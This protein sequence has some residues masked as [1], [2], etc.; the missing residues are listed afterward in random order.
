MSSPFSAAHFDDLHE[1]VQLQ[2][3]AGYLPLAAIVDQAVEIF[4]DL[5]IDPASARAAATAV[6][7]R[8]VAAHRGAQ[9]SWPPVTDCDRLDAAF[10]EL[11]GAGVLAR[12]HYRCCATCATQDILEELQQADKAGRP[13]RG[14]TFFHVQDTE[15]AV[16]GEALYLSY[17]TAETG[18][19][20]AVAVGH[21][22]VDTL[23]R[24]GLEPSWNGRVAHRICLPL[25]WQRR[26]G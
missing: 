6:A 23:R 4:S 9:A 20:A 2:V 16:G 5:V 13:A 25:Q 17:G 10:T 15:H 18:S 21:E 19:T 7:D 3:A 1:F 11:D 8:A 24:H 14:Y 12:Q 26:R 22:V